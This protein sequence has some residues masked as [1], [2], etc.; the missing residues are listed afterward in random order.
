MEDNEFKHD[1]LENI[2]R[3]ADEL[4]EI[5]FGIE[6]I[7]NN[8]NGITTELEGIKDG[9]DRIADILSW[10]EYAIWGI[11]ILGIGSI[12]VGIVKWFMNR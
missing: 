5:K 11:G 8:T 12:I 1:I 2:G 6:N 4:N 10:F 9:L 7:K 3:I